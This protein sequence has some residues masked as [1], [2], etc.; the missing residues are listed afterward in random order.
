[1]LRF[2]SF[3]VGKEWKFSVVESVMQCQERNILGQ[4]ML[5]SFKTILEQGPFWIPSKTRAVATLT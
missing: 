3:Q 1:M 5:D 4:D 2:R